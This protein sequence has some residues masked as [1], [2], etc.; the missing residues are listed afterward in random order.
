LIVDLTKTA[1][2]K[3]LYIADPMCSWCYGFGPELTR[4]LKDIPDSQIDILVGGLRAYN[5]QELDDEH[6]QMILG[7]WDKVQEVS[8]LPFNK[9][10][11]SK[12]HFIYDTEPSC[13]AVV[14]A[15]LLTEDMPGEAILYVFHA[16][17]N[18]FYAQAQDITQLDVLAKVVVTALNDFDGDVIF[19]EESFLET[20][21]SPST[22]E[23]TRLHFEQV[24]Q[25]G[26]RGYPVLLLVKP[27]GLHMLTSGFTTSERLIEELKLLQK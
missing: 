20:L 13:R 2:T 8:G 14:A 6:R 9:S 17:Q 24:Q 25:W 10:T 21:L 22:I 11:L 5:T 26:V 19:D 12:P 4:F 27:E 15:K 1:M 3:F 16:L 18:A 7:H 23:E